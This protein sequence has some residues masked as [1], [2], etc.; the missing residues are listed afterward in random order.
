[1]N[2]FLKFLVL[3]L[4]LL[5]T[6]VYANDAAL[7]VNHFRSLG[8]D[9]NRNPH[10][11]YLQLLEI[12][13]NKR[14]A[15]DSEAYLW[16]LYRK[17][18][19]EKLLYF[20]DRFEQ[21]VERV[22][23]LITSSTDTEIIA[24]IAI[25][26]GILAQQKGNYSQAL[27]HL[28]RSLKESRRAGLNALYVLAKQ[29]A[30][31]TQTLNERYETSLVDMQEAYVAAFALNDY[32]LIAIINETYGA[33]Y[34][35]ID[36][37][38]K[39]IEYYQKAFDAYER[40][41]YQPYVA[42]AVYGLATTYRYWKK[43]D[44]ASQ[45][46]RQYRE[47]ISYTPNKDI[48]FFGEYGLGVN[49][50]QNGECEQAISVI[51]Y[52]LT[53][54]GQKD[55]NAEL[56]KHKS[57]CLIQ[58]NQLQEAKVALDQAKAIYGEMPELDGTSWQLGLVKVDAKLLYAQGHIEQGFLKLQEYYENYTDLLISNASQKIIRIR[59]TMDLERLDIEISSLKQREKYQQLK[60]KEQKQQVTQ[61]YFMITFGVCIM[62]FILIVVYLQYRSNKKI[63][64]L[65]IT[66]SLTGVF[67]RRYIFDHLEKLLIK[68]SGNKGE[69]SV[70][71]F[72]IDDFKQVNDQH[73]HP[74]G[75][76]VLCRIAEI[77]QSTLR[78]GDVLG[79][80]GGEEFFCILPRTDSQ[81]A[82]QVAERLKD[83]IQNEFLCTKDNEQVMV[84]VSI[85]IAELGEVAND[86]ASLYI[87]SDKAL[88]QAKQ[89]GKNQVVIA[90]T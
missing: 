3:S 55:Y 80:I 17:A 5:A 21:T 28:D 16:L 69:L 4:W 84:T 73:G 50:A 35:Y 79:R 68:T 34:G 26:Q 39:S 77:T 30:A 42:E 66:D 65:S 59:E 67:N 40:L 46:Y 18:Q 62:I 19:S 9:I 48:S 82:L 61:Q 45:K 37:Y 44:L 70:L 33:I 63:F 31:Y 74:F 53:L 6:Q 14:D 8:D 38:E 43:F 88:Y 24:A 23:S 49:Y 76:S 7:S 85:G 71:L 87:Q 20:N 1:M 90:A 81:M 58:L 52:A 27:A 12:E 10:P 22:A 83:N 64:A 57:E 51:D 54:N 32:F 41:G 86:R 75:D 89:Q 13:K 2:L 47:K 56:F 72:D 60:V 36:D 29:E 78:M 25:Y 11:V 15:L